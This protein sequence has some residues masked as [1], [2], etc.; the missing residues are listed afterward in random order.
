M[1][2]IKGLLL[3]G[4]FVFSMIPTASFAQVTIIGVTIFSG[5]GAKY[6]TC[7]AVQSSADPNSM[8]PAERATA[9]RDCKQERRDCRN[10]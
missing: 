10:N 2:K 9:L 6:R 1:N 3:M 7:K 4:V 8:D 5:C